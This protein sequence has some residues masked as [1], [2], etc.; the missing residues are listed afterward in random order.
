ME[1]NAIAVDTFQPPKEKLK[2]QIEARWKN[3]GIVVVL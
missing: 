2:C 3:S 1:N